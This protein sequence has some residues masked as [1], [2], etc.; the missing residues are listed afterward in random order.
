MV[1]TDG[2]A[3]LATVV[4]QSTDLN[5]MLETTREDWLSSMTRLANN[6]TLQV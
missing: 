5:Q 1:I 2:S 6:T 4:W 3:G